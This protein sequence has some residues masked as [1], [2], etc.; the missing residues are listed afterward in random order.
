MYST[1]CY[2]IC[3]KWSFTTTLVFLWF[4]NK[5]LGTASIGGNG[6]VREGRMSKLAACISTLERKLGYM[7]RP[8]LK[9]PQLA[10]IRP[11]DMLAQQA[12]G[13]MMTTVAVAN[14]KPLETV[15][16]K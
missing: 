13:Q 11:A 2:S 4:G 12:R 7:L 6:K 5:L 15:P 1:W 10:V 8:V 16:Q 14:G 9:A 3:Q